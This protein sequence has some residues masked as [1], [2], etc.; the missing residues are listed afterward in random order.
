MLFSAWREETEEGAVGVTSG[1]SFTSLSL[2][3]N[4]ADVLKLNS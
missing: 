3:I 4:S 2:K 1:A